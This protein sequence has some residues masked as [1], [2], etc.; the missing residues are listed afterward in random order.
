LPAD[1]VEASLPVDVDAVPVELEFNVP[2]VTGPEVEALPDGDDTETGFDVVCVDVVEVGVVDV[3][4]VFVGVVV[5]GVVVVGVVDV[6]VVDVWVGSI[7][8]SDTVGFGLVVT[9]VAGPDVGALPDGEEVGAAPGDCVGEF[10]VW[11]GDETGVGDP[12][13]V[14]EV[15]CCGVVV[16]GVGIVP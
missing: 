8:D 1:V 14:G 5:V 11:V 15:G 13:V 3:G 9:G 7:G 16:V 10:E 4:V 2:D 12:E 6:G